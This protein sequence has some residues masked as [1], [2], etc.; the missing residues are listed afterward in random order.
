MR[1]LSPGFLAELR[2]GPLLERVHADSSLDLQIR[3]EYVNVYYRGGMLLRWSP[4]GGE[5]DAKYALGAP[6]ELPSSGDLHGWIEAFPLLKDLIDRFPKGADEREIQQQIVRANNYGP[7]ARP[8]DYYVCDIEYAGDHGRFDL[9]LVEWA[10]TQRK[11]TDGHRL[12]LCEL[13]HGQGAMTGPA[14]IQAHMRQA[15]A[16]CSDPARVQALKSE[17][18]ALFNQKR[19]LGLVDCDKDLTGFSDKKPMFL[20][21]CANNNPRSSVMGREIRAGL[22]LQHVELALGGGLGGALY[23]SL[24]TPV[25]FPP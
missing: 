11:R 5:F 2:S 16:F 19:A 25:V 8:T 9:V 22:P 17:M 20:L 10:G 15:D 3:R 24:V 18:V 7:H 14:G 4:A 23:R 12:V 6:L 1:G 13:K 21:V